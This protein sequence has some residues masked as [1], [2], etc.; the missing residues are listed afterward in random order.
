MH[1]NFPGSVRIKRDFYVDD[2]LTGSNSKFEAIAIRDQIIEILK[3]RCF[4]LSKWGSNSPELLED[5]GEQSEKLIVFDKDADFR[6]LGIFSGIEITMY[7]A[8]RTILI[9]LPRPLLSVSY[10][11]KYPNCLIHGDSSVRLS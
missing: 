2:L 3:R 7:F 11:R 1:T 9:N 4:Q 10:F 5:V 6:L 8:F